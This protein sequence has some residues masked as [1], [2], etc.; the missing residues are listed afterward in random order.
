VLQ[1]FVAPQPYLQQVKLLLLAAARRVFGPL[2]AL[3]QGVIRAF[4]GYLF[5]LLV[6]RIVGRRPGK[7][8]TPFEFVLVFFIGGLALTAI[9]GDERSF[10]NATCQIFTFGVAH[11]LV[12]WGRSKSPKFAML[13]DGTPLTLPKMENGNARR[14][15]KCALQMTMSCLQLGTTD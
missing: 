11:Y 14:C 9:V 12:S 15:S 5:L 6:V 4:F 10:T 3:M 8:F 7:Q 2:L 13:I 1:H